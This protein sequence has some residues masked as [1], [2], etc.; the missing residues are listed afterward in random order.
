MNSPFFSIC[1]PNFNYG[2]YLHET[3]DSVLSQ[4][5]NDFEICIA[6]NKSTDNSWEVITEYTNKHNNI[7]AIQN[8]QNLGF[9]GNLDAVS[10]ISTGKW[11]IMLSSDDL[12]EPGALSLYYKCI[13]KDNNTF[14]VYN[15]SVTQFNNDKPE[16]QKHIGY[17][18]PIWN[19]TDKSEH[20][21]T[22][23]GCE[24][25][26]KSCNKLLHLGLKTSKSP[27][28]FVSLCYSREIYNLV[29]GYGSTRMINPDKWFHFRLCSVANE[30]IY[31]DQVCFKYRWHNNNQTAQQ[32]QS[33]A[34][35]FW[36]DEYR[37]S[38]E[39][40]KDLLQKIGLNQLDV[41]KA[42]IENVILPY[43][44]RHL[45]LKERKMSWRI[46]YLGLATYP[47]ICFRDFRFY[48]LFILLTLGPLGS[49]ISKLY[50]SSPNK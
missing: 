13:T 12:M 3:I 50:T 33:G 21:T 48:F 47:E 43:M 6:D 34:L 2:N 36:I 49:L 30:A 39:V 8:T 20:W 35:K 16:E 31:M 15:S 22:I 24:T 7:K 26:T 19:N 25:Y 29:S 10:K 4:D 17:R 18:K 42:Y 40:D 27:F 32:T 14:N 45:R 37:T 28:N 23:L 41:K 46:L 44:L 11:M 38:F 1:I 5:F 9:A